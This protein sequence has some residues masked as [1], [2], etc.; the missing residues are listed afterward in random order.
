MYP[1]YEENKYNAN[2]TF[3]DEAKT[4]RFAHDAGSARP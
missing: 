4:A 2:K 1:K 3:I